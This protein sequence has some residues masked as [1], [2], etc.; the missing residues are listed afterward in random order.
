M[1]T[2]LQLGEDDVDWLTFNFMKEIGEDIGV[3]MRSK[4]HLDEFT[5]RTLERGLGSF[6]RNG[7]QFKFGRV[8]QHGDMKR[9]F[10]SSFK[11]SSNED[12]FMGDQRCL[13][14]ISFG[15]GLDEERYCTTHLNELEIPSGRDRNK[16]T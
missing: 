14:G 1:T 2:S 11:T 3:Q 16:P 15:I 6:I 10:G 8:V 7:I 12:R 4:T 13:F 9:S 5:R